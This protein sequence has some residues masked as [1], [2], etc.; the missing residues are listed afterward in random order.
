MGAGCAIALSG[1]PV[2][3]RRPASMRHHGEHVRDISCHFQFIFSCGREKNKS[4]SLS[5]ETGAFN[6]DLH[7]HSSA[8]QGQGAAV[9][10]GVR[11][12]LLARRRLPSPHV[13]T[14]DRDPSLSSSSCAATNPV[15][16]TR[17]MTSSTRMPSRRESGLQHLNLGCEGD[18]VQ[19]IAISD[20]VTGIVLLVRGSGEE[21]T[22]L[23]WGAGP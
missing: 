18:T 17:R 15:T 21:R 22:V 20:R 12:L 19:S 23:T 3:S 14:W 7:S 11:A 13:L 16:G 6:T 4:G 10:C 1:V 9:L 8:R 2:T 5:L